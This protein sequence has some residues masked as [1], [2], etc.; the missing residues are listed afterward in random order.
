MR[1]LILLIGLLTVGLVAAKSAPGR[2]AVRYDN[3]KVYQVTIE[4]D[5]QM[6]EL[7]KI[8]EHITVHFLNELAGPGRTYNLIV[9]PLFQRSLEKTL[10]FLEIVYKV[11]VEDLQ[12]LLDEASVGDDSHM[13]WETYHTL[14]T[15][16]DW[17]DQECAAHDYLE[18]KVIGK[19]HEG[20]DIKGVRLS[21]RS[22][23]KA[24]LL[25]GN[26]HAM[27][28]I[29]SATVTF[30]LNQLI[31]S[32][33]PEM[34]RL[35]EEYDWIVVPMVNP[36]GFVYT[37]EVERLWR[38][39]RRPNGH[40]NT[41]GACYGIDMN[42]NFDY[43]WGGA[44]WNIDEPCDHWF[45]GEEPNTEVEILS[46]QDFVSSFDDGY[47]RSYMAFHAYG[48]YVLLPYGHS[49]TEFPPNYEQ[50]QRIAAA[51]SDAAAEVYGSTFTYGASG[52]LNYVVSG[53]AKDWAYGVKNIPFT[54]TVELRDKGTFGFFLPSNQIT[55]VGIE[56]TAGLKA[57]VN[58]A[59]EEGIFD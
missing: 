27:E 51:F 41:T 48:Q 8:H 20:R 28:W 52:L 45:G 6:E 22:G 39:N 11:I 31:N 40:M 1:L 49:N 37:H 16:Y 21:K 19:S 4:T 23:N 59:Q 47:I 38:K 10:N 36:D 56:V 5:L 25:E 35:S 54:C 46:L 14:D 29:S 42:R 55:E 17:V 53:A 57:L 2:M 18:C 43:H 30:L 33:D 26:I 24:I 9:G 7:R 58:K 34:Q 15:I 44:G 12:K 50:M 3:F 13:E 32:E